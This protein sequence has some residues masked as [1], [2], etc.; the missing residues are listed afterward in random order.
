MKHLQQKQTVN[1]LALDLGLTLYNKQAKQYN[2]HRR[3]FI[4]LS[5]EDAHMIVHTT[6]KKQSYEQSKTTH[7]PAV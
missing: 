4:I 5:E 7:R 2:L 6:A 3:S 1:E